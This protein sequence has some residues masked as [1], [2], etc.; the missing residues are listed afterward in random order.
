MEDSQ[1]AAVDLVLLVTSD[2]IKVCRKPT[3]DEQLQVPKLINAITGV[4]LIIINFF[5]GERNI[6]L[7]AHHFLTIGVSIPPRI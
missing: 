1:A 7:K 4:I 6:I 3:T 5:T 2:R